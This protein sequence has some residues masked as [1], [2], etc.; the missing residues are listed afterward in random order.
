MNFPRILLWMFVK[1]QWYL[2]LG[3]Y[4][5]NSCICLQIFS[6]IC[7]SNATIRIKYIYNIITIVYLH[8]FISLLNT[9]CEQPAE[10]TE[11]TLTYLR[12]FYFWNL[13]LQMY[14][15]IY[16]FYYAATHTQCFVEVFLIDTQW[17]KI[18][19]G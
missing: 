4:K 7:I 11:E 15:S 13:K 5:K 17:L 6:V 8:C 16:C 3:L 1:H 10:F 18:L 12:V 19:C 14:I 9:R 2:N